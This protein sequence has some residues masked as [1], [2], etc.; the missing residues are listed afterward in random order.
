MSS[1]VRS[2]PKT[3]LMISIMVIFGPVGNVLLS[4]GMKSVGSIAGL[5]AT[6]LLQL[7]GRVLACGTIWLG[8]AS[9]LTFFIANMLVL[10]WADYSYVLPASAMGYGTV[11]LLGHFVL[12]EAVTPVRWLGIIVI[13]MGVFVVGQTP[14]GSTQPVE[15]DS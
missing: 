9:L 10:T 14:H 2:Y 7:L 8:I 13:C 12:G 15:Q 1:S 11:A 6:G 5:D 4:K 3:Y